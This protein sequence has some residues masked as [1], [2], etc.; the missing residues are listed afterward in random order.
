[1]R[2]GIRL[3]GF[4]DAR[5]DIISDHS[6]LDKDGISVL[7]FADPFA[8]HSDIDYADLDLLTL[9][10]LGRLILLYCHMMGLFTFRLLSG[11]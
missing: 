1:M 10:I 2:I 4:H 11:F 7:Q 3:I 8:S 5:P 9:P 6:V